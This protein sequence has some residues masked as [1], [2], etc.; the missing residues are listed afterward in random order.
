MIRMRLTCGY[1]EVVDEVEPIACLLSN[2]WEL[3]LRCLYCY[4]MLVDVVWV[5]VSMTDVRLL[6]NGL[7]KVATLIHIWVD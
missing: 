3:L 6:I 7:F 1:W 5:S 4:A 2:L